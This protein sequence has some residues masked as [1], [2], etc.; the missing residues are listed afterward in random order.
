[1]KPDASQFDVLTFDCYGTIIDWE[2]GLLR[3]LKPTLVAHAVSL[4]DEDLLARYGELEAGIQAGAFRKYA[5]V[6]ASVL[7]GFGREYDFEPS[8]Q[9]VLD[10]SRSVQHWPPFA[11]SAAALKALQSKFRL[12]VLSNIDDDLFEFSR[13]QLG[14]TFDRVFTAQQIGSYKPS[15]RNFQYMLER[16]GVPKDR[17][18][19]VAQGLFHDIV[20]TRALGIRN[21]WVNR[22]SGRPGSGATLGSDVKPDFEVPDLRS[23]A[24]A[25]GLDPKA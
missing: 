25:F 7:S 1:M 18:L 16:V 9:E 24:Q 8:A 20:P 14:V 19:H 5:D 12:V 15:L 10:F 23:L 3:T 2:T 6:L 22:R 17:I 4:S 11:D 21:V 13:A